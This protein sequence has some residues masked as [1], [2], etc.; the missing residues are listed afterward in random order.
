MS[1]EEL[2]SFIKSPHLLS[3][4]GN[5]SVSDKMVKI[6]EKIFAVTGGFVATGL[7]FRKS[8]YMQ[9]YFL[10]TVSE[11]AKILLKKKV[12]LQGSVDAE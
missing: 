5:E 4:E 11:D 6:M 9:N 3:C 8:Y 1:V 10:D 2:K 7:Y 12:F